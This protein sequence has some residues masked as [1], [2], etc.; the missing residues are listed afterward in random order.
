MRALPL[1]LA[2]LLLSTVAAAQ[3]DP[4]AAVR[5][6]IAVR[7]ETVTVGDPLVLSV[8]VQAPQGATIE[9]PSGPDSGGTV[10][11]TASRRVQ[12]R[13]VAGVVEQ[14]ATYPL[15]AWDVGD[16]APAFGDVVV[17]LGGAE[18]RIPLGDVTIHVRSVLPADTTLH[19]P[20]PPRPPLDVP[21]PWWRR[22]WP[23]IV[24]ALLAALLVWWLWRRRG[25]PGG[26]GREDAL[27]FAEREFARVEAL[28]LVEAGERGRHVALMV[29]VLRDYLARRLPEARASLTSSELLA[30]LRASRLVPHA[31]LAAVLEEAD[32]VKFARRPLSAERARELGRDARGV[33]RD[34]ERAVGEQ[35][36]AAERKAAA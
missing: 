16:L 24:A 14:T 18:R 25:R 4:L 13:D 3:D 2:A 31:R 21:V 12:P 28:G 32:L 34:V 17:R 8:R 6:G 19:V 15:V 1:A 33:V 27:V 23:F 10:E 20:K 30:A 9:F 11:P 7:P 36:A 29:D 26:A 5:L 35:A 22:W